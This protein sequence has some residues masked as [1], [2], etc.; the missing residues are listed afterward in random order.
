MQNGD[1]VQIKQIFQGAPHWIYAKVHSVFADGGAVVV[2]DH[3]QNPE[4]GA[5]KIVSATDLRTKE[6]L[7]EECDAV[8]GHDELAREQRRQLQVQIDQLS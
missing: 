7:Q 1:R 8:E 3:S 4:H 5:T 6:D 2:V